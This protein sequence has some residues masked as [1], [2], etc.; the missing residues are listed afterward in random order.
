MEMTEGCQRSLTHLHRFQAFLCSNCSNMMKRC[1]WYT[2]LDLRRRHK[3]WFCQTNISSK[4]VKL[5]LSTRRSFKSHYFIIFRLFH[6]WI[7][8]F[9]VHD[10]WTEKNEVRQRFHLFWHSVATS[11]PKA[12][13]LITVTTKP[14]TTLVHNLNLH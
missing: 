8:A 13:N 12:W 1:C 6:R 11:L 7:N 14:M 3:K 4:N 2:L 9:I 5:S 10:D